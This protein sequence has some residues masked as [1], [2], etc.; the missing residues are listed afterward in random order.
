MGIRIRETVAKKHTHKVHREVRC[1]AWVNCG[2]WFATR[3]VRMVRESA[4][5]GGPY[6]VN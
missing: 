6:C 1:K 5:S 3:L 2:K 4:R